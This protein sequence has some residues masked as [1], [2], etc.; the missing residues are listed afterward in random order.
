MLFRDLSRVR[1][2]L[3]TF[4]RWRINDQRLIFK[5][6]AIKITGMSRNMLAVP[7]RTVSKFRYG[8]L[9]TVTFCW[10]HPVLLRPARFLIRTVTAVANFLTVLKSGTAVTAITASQV[11]PSRRPALPHVHPVV[12]LALSA[13]YFRINHGI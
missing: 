12:N 11:C 10:V 4:N 2:R 9:R 3:L 5:M 6:A 8:L 1:I 13:E 7:L